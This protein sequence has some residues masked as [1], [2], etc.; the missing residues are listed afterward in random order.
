MRV[1]VL[2]FTGKIPD[3]RLTD[4][5]VIV[6]DVLRATSSIVWAIRNGAERIIP[7]TDPGTAVAMQLRLGNAERVL[8]GERG[9]VRIPGFDI[10][11]SPMDFTEDVVKNKLVIM[12]T[13][14]GTEAICAVKSAKNVLIGSMLNRTAVA[15]RA[16]EIGRDILIICAGT[17]GQLS[18]DDMCAAGGIV[19]AVTQFAD[20]F[21]AND[22]A[23]I[24]AL[25][26]AGWK[27]G[28][29]DL[30]VTMHYSRLIRLGFARDAE[31]CFREDQTDVVPQLIDGI[32]S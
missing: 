14:N 18:A 26:Y 11:N 10:G 4:A 28:E 9:G 29:A 8:A 13:T 15:K 5:T 7:V 16:V 30:S 1:D 24:A 21:S 3:N 17:E 22:A 6:V 32:I 31:F 20:E 23:L 27:K 25:L 2:N 12:S 19:E